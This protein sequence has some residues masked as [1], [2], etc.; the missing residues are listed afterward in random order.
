MN[1]VPPR[2]A[3][4]LAQWDYMADVLLARLTGLTDV[5]FRWEAAPGSLTV[6]ETAEGSTPQVHGLPPDASG[7][8]PRTLAWSI[9]HLGATAL[10]RADYLVGDH[11]L[12]IAE[13]PASA[14]DGVRFLREG[15]AAWREGIGGMTDEDLD[16]V[17]RS[18][19]PDGLDPELPL[20][21]IIWWMNK[22]LIFHSGEIWLARDLYAARTPEGGGDDASDRRGATGAP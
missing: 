5:E 14:D 10:V 17:G 18:A 12:E 4:F 19:F 22:E 2:L 11:S 7:Q 21:D 15:L 16:T 1:D 13:W 8:P 20:L 9:G 3:P 6:R